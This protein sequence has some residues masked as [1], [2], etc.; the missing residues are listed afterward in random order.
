M[1]LKVSL[2]LIDVFAGVVLYI[3]AWRIFDVYRIFIFDN[4]CLKSEYNIVVI[5]VNTVQ[6]TALGSLFGALWIILDP[7]DTWLL[8]GKTATS[9]RDKRLMRLTKMSSSRRQILRQT[10]SIRESTST[11]K[12]KTVFKYVKLQ[13][14]KFRQWYRANLS[15]TQGKYYREKCLVQQGYSTVFTMIAVDAYARTIDR[16]FIWVWMAILCF[17]VVLTPIGFFCTKESRHRRLKITLGSRLS[18]SMIDLLSNLFMLLLKY[19]I[20]TEMR[21]STS[22]YW[23]RYGLAK[24]ITVTVTDAVADTVTISSSAKVAMC[25]DEFFQAAREQQGGAPVPGSFDFYVM[26][27]FLVWKAIHLNYMT[28]H[29]PR[30]WAEWWWKAGHPSATTILTNMFTNS[31]TTRSTSTARTPSNNAP[32]FTALPA[33]IKKKLKKARKNSLLDDAGVGES[34]K[35]VGIGGDGGDGGNGGDGGDAAVEIDLTETS[36]GKSTLANIRHVESGANAD[37]TD[38]DVVALELSQISERKSADLSNNSNGGADGADGAKRA[39]EPPRQIASSRVLSALSSTSTRT[40]SIY[41]VENTQNT[42]LSSEEEKSRSASFSSSPKG[43]SFISK[44]M[45]SVAVAFKRRYKY[46]YCFIAHTPA[47]T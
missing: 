29:L 31:W 6:V 30:R 46:V 3:V 22:T 45:S 35:S 28:W 5:S 39:D 10:S 16:S 42:T 1:C 26:I 38:L 15:L 32:A 40:P 18:A 12:C 43:G 14:L 19:F 27:F 11:R 23:G 20:W 4:T 47:L 2:I 36:E 17:D 21:G 9:R 7:H 44:K 37:A 8:L 41:F 13:V 24:N 34:V 25:S 33:V